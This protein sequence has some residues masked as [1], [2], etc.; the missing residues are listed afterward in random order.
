[1]K[2][3]SVKKLNNRQCR[4]KSSNKICDYHRY[5]PY[6]S[7]N[8]TKTY[9]RLTNRKRRIESEDVVKTEDTDKYQ[10]KRIRFS[11]REVKKERTNN[12]LL[13]KL[14]VIL[15]V[16][17]LFVNYEKIS[18]EFKN[19]YEYL[20]EKTKGV[21]LVYLLQVYQNVYKQVGN[22]AMD[23]YKDSHHLI[24]TPNLFF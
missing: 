15:F 13:M 23:V 24:E 12:T 17:S 14:F 3:C 5:H 19:G 7:S 9:Q 18:F 8:G 6:I 2:I 11:E 10:S 1:M 22:F 4:N 20:E 16:L 21:S